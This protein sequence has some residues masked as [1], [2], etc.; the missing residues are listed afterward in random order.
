MDSFSNSKTLT[1]QTENI[2]PSDNKAWSPLPIKLRKVEDGH[3]V[4]PFAVRN[5]TDSCILP[6]Q[7]KVCSFKSFN[8]DNSAF[9][10]TFIEYNKLNA[11][12]LAPLHKTMSTCLTADTTAS[13]KGLKEM[14]SSLLKKRIHKLTVH[15][16]HETLF[17][18]QK[19]NMVTPR[20]RPA[21]APFSFNNIPSL[22]VVRAHS[23]GYANLFSNLL[24]NESGCGTPSEDKEDHRHT[25][26]C[27]HNNKN[28][29][30]HHERVGK[31]LKPNMTKKKTR[32]CNCKNSKCLK[33]Y[34]ECLAHGEYCDDSCNC[35]D[36]S[37]N[38][39]KEEVRAYALS[40]IME[41]KPSI[42]EG[43]SLKKQNT[44][45]IVRGKGCNCKKSACSKK[46]CECY[47]SGAGCGAHCKCEGCK[48]PHAK[49]ET[50]ESTKITESESPISTYIPQ[51]LDLNIKEGRFLDQP[52]IEA[53]LRLLKSQM[54][55][56][57]PLVT[58]ELSETS[59]CSLPP[60]F[61]SGFE[62]KL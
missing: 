16:D 23:E 40:L 31:F 55:K 2:E 42:L 46:Y 11:L 21:L 8:P 3:S 34:C 58:R 51:G 5:N 12:D 37:N 60:L 4:K 41:K 25:I 24:R 47:N 49:T 59:V 36:C 50:S 7:N 32:H 57:L 39:Q 52:T 33:L 10:K 17:G 6:W 26:N 53:S 1:M 29:Q 28:V 14:S 15:E 56:T 43:E 13:E 18:K 61:F 38:T 45:K 54:Q 20:F 27:S 62:N 19:A 22:Q 48:N 44:S 30:Q 35:C 9:R